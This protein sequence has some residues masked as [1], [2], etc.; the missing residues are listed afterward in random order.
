MLR[1][2]NII[3]II[4]LL[5]SA[6][7]AYAIKYETMRYSAEIVKA[8]HAIQREKDAIS[9][10]RAEWS[11][12]SRPTRVQALADRHLDLQNITVDQIVKVADLPDRA[13][14][15]DTIGRKLESLGMSEPTATPRDDRSAVSRSATPSSTR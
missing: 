7:Y 4:A 2:L 15:V 1:Y 10:L 9:M 11:H 5:G 12:L 3:P 6:V 8:Q 13:A 14:R